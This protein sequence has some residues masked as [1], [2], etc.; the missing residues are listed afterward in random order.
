M[1][2]CAH[3]NFFKFSVIKILFSYFLDI[4]NLLKTR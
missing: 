4:S 1:Y 2:T 3:F